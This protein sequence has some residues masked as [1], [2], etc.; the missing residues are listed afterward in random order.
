MGSDLTFRKI[1]ISCSCMKNFFVFVFRRTFLHFLPQNEKNGRAILLRG[2]YPSALLQDPVYIVAHEETVFKI[3]PFP[4]WCF[5]INMKTYQAKLHSSLHIRIYWGCGEPDS[6]LKVPL[7]RTFSSSS[8]T[9]LAL[10]SLI[11]T[12]LRLLLFL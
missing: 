2:L 11:I 7:L 12:I 10:S 6:G 9:L 8:S 3:S 4:I 1:W 5:L